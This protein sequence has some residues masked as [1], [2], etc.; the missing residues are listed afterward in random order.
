MQIA[1]LLQILRIMCRE[2]LI[3]FISVEG[4]TPTHVLPI[5]TS[6]VHKPG[7]NAEPRSEH[8]Q[9]ETLQRASTG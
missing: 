6:H 9:S 5:M 8:I 7:K 4:V 3:G 1:V 2:S